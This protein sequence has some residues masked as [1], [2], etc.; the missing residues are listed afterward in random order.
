[1]KYKLKKPLTKEDL[2]NTKWLID[3]PEKCEALLLESI[4]L[5]FNDLLKLKRHLVAKVFYFHE[6]NRVEWDRYAG[7]IFLESIK[8]EM[9]FDDWFEEDIKIFGMGIEGNMHK[10]LTENM[11]KQLREDSIFLNAED[12]GKYKGTWMWAVKQIGEGKKVRRHSWGNDSCY[13]LNDF[14]LLELD[15][16]GGND[17]ELYED[18]SIELARFMHDNYEELS[19]E[20]GWKTQDSCQV[21]FDDLPEANKIVMFKIAERVIKHLKLK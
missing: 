4:P 6:N 19:K 10:P 18:E 14:S 3:A 21:E 13:I 1:M 7:N 2:I 5:G 16:F 9:N 12:Y 17:W 11:Q 20:V 8:K 15:D